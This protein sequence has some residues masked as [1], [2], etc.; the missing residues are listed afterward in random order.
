MFFFLYLAGETQFVS[1]SVSKEVIVCMLQAKSQEGNLI[2]LANL[3]EEEIEHYR[4]NIKFYCPTCGEPVLVKAGNMVTPHFAHQAIIDCESYGRGEGEYHENGKLL[5]YQWLKSQGLKVELEK[6]IREIKQQPDILVT[7]KNKKIAIEYQCARVPIEQIQI[8][9]KGY[10]QAGIIPLWILGANRFKRHDRNRIKV[11]QFIL[12]FVHQFSATHPLTLFFFCPHTLEFITFQDMFMT[13]TSYTLGCFTFR[14]LNKMIMTDLFSQAKFTPQ[15]LYQ[16]WKREK[17]RFRLQQRKTSFGKERAWQ[18]YLYLK[19]TH[20]EYLPSIIN[21]PVSHQF[22]MKSPLWDWQTRL[23]LDVLDPLPIGRQFTLNH[24]E[25]RLRNQLHQHNYF[26]LVR[27][28]EN[29]II[30]YLHLLKVLKYIEESS[31]YTYTKINA[32]TH[33]CHIEESILGDERILE[34]LMIKSRNKMKHE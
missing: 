24:C 34:E 26:P 32:I 10:N 7:L 22:K 25:Q 29:P 4:K 15:Q 1:N 27:S 17:R 30:Q 33:H 18:Q 21:L 5:L 8:R 11:D 20:L 6:Y 12:Q 9:N 19:Q 28:T 23:C 13:Q 14:K 2:T 3:T 16:H 31:P